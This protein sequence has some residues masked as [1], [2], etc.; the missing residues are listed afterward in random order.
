MSLLGEE[1]VSRGRVWNRA[2]HD[3]IGIVRVT[4]ALYAPDGSRVRGN[5]QRSV[6]VDGA[7]VS[8]V[9]RLILEALGGIA[10]PAHT[11]RDA[12]ESV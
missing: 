1:K 9:N 6:I 5:R 8:E 4:L 2:D 12:K 3:G 11:K 10:R 7:R